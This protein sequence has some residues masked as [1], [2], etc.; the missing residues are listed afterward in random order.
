MVP[1]GQVWC[2]HTY[3]PTTQEG[4]LGSISQ[5]PGQPALF[6]ELQ[7]AQVTQ[8]TPSLIVRIRKTTTTTT[9]Q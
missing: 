3:N 8:E 7:A 9:Q 1:S 2:P 4:E 5:M 6:D